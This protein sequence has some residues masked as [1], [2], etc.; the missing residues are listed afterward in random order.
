MKLSVVIPA[1]N[2]EG[3]IDATVGAIGDRLQRAEIDYEILVVDDASADRTGQIA[4]GLGAADARVRC[5]RSP[6]PNGF[7]FAVRAGLER[8]DGDAVAIMMADA[9]DDPDDAVAY[10]RLLCACCMSSSSTT[11]A[12]ATTGARTPSRRARGAG[13]S[14][15]PAR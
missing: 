15:P 1:H 3:S 8:F 5:L 6:Y 7:G 9:S 11:S 4:R 10:H 13:A 12:V 2:E 14:A